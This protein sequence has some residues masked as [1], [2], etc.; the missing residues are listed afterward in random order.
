M[1]RQTRPRRTGDKHTPHPRSPTTDGSDDEL[2]GHPGPDDEVTLDELAALRAGELSAE[3]EARLRM[4]MAHDPRAEDKLWALDNV[5]RL[6]KKPGPAPADLPVEM[7]YDVAAR[8]HAKIFR[9]ALHRAERPDDQ[10]TGPRPQER[11]R[12]HETEDP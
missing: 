4:R 8:L 7:P 12:D 1:I 6:F 10:D 5:H 11:G 2:S 9:W 3:Q